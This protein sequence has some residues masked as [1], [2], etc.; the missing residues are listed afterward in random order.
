MGRS[1]MP[2]A[3]RRCGDFARFELAEADTA[4]S[5][6]SGTWSIAF[7]EH[8]RVTGVRTSERGVAEPIDF[9]VTSE[10]GC[11]GAG[12]WR[13]FTDSSSPVTFDYPADWR[14]EAGP[15]SV[16]RTCPN[17][18]AM[19]R[20]GHWIELTWGSGDASKPRPR[21]DATPRSSSRSSR[22][23]MTV[24][25]WS[26]MPAC[27][28]SHRRSSATR[29]VRSRSGGQRRRHASASQHSPTT[30]VVPAGELPRS[31]SSSRTTAGCGCG[32]ADGCHGGRA[33]SR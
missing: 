19:A 27:A 24:G 13:S 30:P 14:M 3:S 17:L 11:D 15:T 9:A 31:R 21:M 18:E 32:A 22:S 25:V 33:A 7:T 10:P 23:G 2:A 20:G 8:G 1:R 26:R 6:R 29:R 12:T 28:R 16:T 4:T 5:G